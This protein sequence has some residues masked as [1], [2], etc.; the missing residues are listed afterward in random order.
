MLPALHPYMDSDAGRLRRRAGFLTGISA[1]LIW[2]ALPIYWKL[3]GFMDPFLT[4][5]H[6]V[7]WSFVFL[8][9][10]EL[11]KK[12]LGTT[13]SHLSNRRVIVVVG[14]RSLLISI[15]WL[16][17][18]WAVVTG[19]IV[20]ASLGYFFTPIVSILTGVFFFRERP[21]PLQWAS[22]LLAFSGV[23][24]QILIFGDIPW[25]AITLGVAFSVYGAMR[26]VDACGSL[27]GLFQ[28]TLIIMPIVLVLLGGYAAFQGDIGLSASTGQTLLIACSGIVT[29]VPLLL[30]AYSAQRLHMI[31]IG[32]M[33]Y[34]D[35]SLNLVIGVLMYGEKVTQGQR[36][37][38]G[39]IWLALILFSGESL[40][41]HR[42]TV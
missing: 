8:L 14:F 4:M 25:I 31:T 41:L 32:L 11:W 26:K 18:I 2:G 28:E 17:F 42:K 34:I 19:R 10:L 16:L 38:F 9:A 23:G 20:E 12:T 33:Q 3:L 21:T 27:E 5:L 30:F 13:L 40:R 24:L 29:S 35:P 6:R 39:C 36:I 15:N 37:S 7:F 22:I 1:Y